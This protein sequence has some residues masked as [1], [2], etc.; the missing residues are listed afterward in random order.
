M[1]S[2]AKWE[3]WE[4]ARRLRRAALTCPRRCPPHQI[5]QGAEAGVHDR[6]LDR[7]PI[8]VLST[9]EKRDRP[10]ISPIERHG[11]EGP[12]FV[13]SAGP[14]EGQVGFAAD[15]DQISG[16]DDGLLAV[17]DGDQQLED[18]AFAHPVGLP[19]GMQ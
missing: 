18:F 6:R 7:A 11:I 9:E 8:D 16:G 5:S 12:S 13:P 17:H 1:A 4:G 2:P 19:Y 14:L 15:K 10:Q 3:E